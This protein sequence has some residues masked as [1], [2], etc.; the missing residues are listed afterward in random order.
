MK[1]HTEFQVCRRPKQQE[2]RIAPDL[3]R[4][5]ERYTS[6]YPTIRILETSYMGSSAE[7]QKLQWAQYSHCLVCR[8][9]GWESIWWGPDS[10]LWFKFHLS[11]HQQGIVV[12]QFF[13][14]I[15]CQFKCYCWFFLSSF[16]YQSAKIWQLFSHC[17]CALVYK[18]FQLWHLWLCC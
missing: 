3:H 12:C 14:F 16:L 13:S 7:C 9:S 5:C 15:C 2:G 6:L 8:W 1:K 11:L 10:S 4:V 18:M 17:P